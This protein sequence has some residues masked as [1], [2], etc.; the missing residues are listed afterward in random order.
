[1]SILSIACANIFFDTEGYGYIFVKNG[2][3]EK[4]GNTLFTI[5]YYFAKLIP[6]IIFAI[7]ALMLSV[8]TRNT[9]VSLGLS[10]ATYKEA[11]SYHFRRLA[12]FIISFH[13]I[14]CELR[15]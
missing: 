14:A 9:S 7:F 3:V 1:M 11:A 12:A 6:V 2:N 10:I 15:A 5:G 4:I 8:I 13:L